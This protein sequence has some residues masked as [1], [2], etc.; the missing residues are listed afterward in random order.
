MGTPSY[1]GKWRIIGRIIDQGHWYVKG[2]WYGVTAI[3]LSTNPL[4]IR[5]F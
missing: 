5:L 3:K 1:E 2:H 4:K